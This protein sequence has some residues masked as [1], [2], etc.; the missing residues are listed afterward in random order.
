MCYPLIN[1]QKCTS[2]KIQNYFLI[3]LAIKLTI[4]ESTVYTTT[5]IKKDSLNTVKVN[6]MNTT[7]V[8]S[9]MTNHFLNKNIPTIDDKT[10]I[11]GRV[12]NTKP[13]GSF[14]FSITNFVKL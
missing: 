2:N 14:I 4:A 6:M 1:F 12:I 13:K 8:R 9:G 10:T 5:Q 11:V 7:K 3:D